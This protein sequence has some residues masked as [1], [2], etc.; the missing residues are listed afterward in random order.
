M[1]NCNKEE[2]FP[3]SFPPQHQCRQ[4]GIEWEMRPRPVFEDPCYTGSCRLK[5]KTALITGGDSGIGRAAAIAF[6]KEGANLAIVYLNEN[7]DAKETK[8]RIEE[9][10]RECI[11]LCGDIRR[12]SVC[13]QMVE[14]TVSEMGSLDILVNN[15][16]VQFPQN[17][18]ED[19]TEEQLRT[20]FQV[21][22]FPMFFSRGTAHEEGIVL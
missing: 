19:I 17:S 10:G 18:I 12:E 3:T 13:R 20:T 6:A 5:G 2:A 22:L 4:P 15:A 9:L 1:D 14:S 7:E 8:K 11:L 16:G 21:N